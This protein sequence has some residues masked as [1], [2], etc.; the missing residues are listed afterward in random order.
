MNV[1]I[2]IPAY[3]AE[4]FIVATLESCARQ[5]RLALEVI[6][7]DD[8]SRDQTAP[9]ARNCGLAT[10][11]LALEN[12]GVSRARN[13]GAAI[14]RGEAFLFLDADDVLLPSALDTLA[15]ALG[16]PTVGVAYGMVIERRAPPK[17]ARLNG[18]DFCAG[19]PPCPSRANLDRCAI[20]TPGSALIRRSVFEKVGGFVSGTEPLE[21]RDLWLRCGLLTSFAFCDTVVLDKTWCPGS[22]GSQTAKRIYRGWLAKRRL[23]AWGQAAGLEV[24]WIPCDAD[25]VRQALREAIYWKCWEILPTLC[26][27]AEAVGLSGYWPM[28]ARWT[29]AVLRREEP[30]WVSESAGCLSDR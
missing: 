21:D 7:V 24:D 28:R 17:R 14:A 8:G 6:V 4:S 15:R 29:A 19:G 20:I 9:R 18:F 30:A 1:S 10:T 2:I 26:R 5:T 25:L 3:Q 23:R 27:D 12:G 13:A 11:F 16:D 22:H